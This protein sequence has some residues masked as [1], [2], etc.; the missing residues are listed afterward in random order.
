MGNR[1][2]SFSKKLKKVPLLF[3]INLSTDD[4]S[5]FK[6]TICDIKRH[7]NYFINIFYVDLQKHNK[8]FNYIINFFLYISSE[9]VRYF[10]QTI[11]DIKQQMIYF[12]K[13]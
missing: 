11:C 10:K 12:M 9:N 8:I 2:H 13:I 1:G 7:I 4:I 5:H 3:F 6:Q